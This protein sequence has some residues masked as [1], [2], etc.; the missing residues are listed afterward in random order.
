MLFGLCV[1]YFTE[2]R[3]FPGDLRGVADFYCSNDCYWYQN[4]AVN[5]YETKPADELWKNEDGSLRQ[6]SWAFFPLY[7]SINKIVMLAT[8]LD[9]V[10]AAF[11]VVFFLSWFCFL[12]LYKFMKAL[13]GNTLSAYNITLL[14]MLFPFHFYFSMYYTESLFLLLLLLGFYGI[15]KQNYLLLAVSCLL[16]PLVRVN[17]IIMM[18]PLG[19]YLME[20][21]NISFKMLIK[22]DRSKI[23]FALFIPLLGL[24]TFFGWSYYQYL[25]TGSFKAFSLAQTGWDRRFVFPLKSFFAMRY[26]EQQILSV[27]TI[28][29]FIPAILASVK[30]NNSFRIIIWIGM[31]LPLTAGS[32]LSLPRYISVIFPMFKYL[33][34]W[35]SRF[36]YLPFIFILLFLLQLVTYYFYLISHPFGY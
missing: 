3:T 14:T 25:K 18:L 27:Y 12:M 13:T 26:W 9:Y 33:G 31:L 17:G 29:M 19:I 5:W 20:K 11:I 16:L 7:P 2:F 32:V 6:S 36:K 8:G 24:L 21:E 30:Q 4:I 28:I 15:E 23:N 10:F 22:F 34:E 35:I 1:A